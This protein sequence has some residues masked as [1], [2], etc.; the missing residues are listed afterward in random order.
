MCEHIGNSWTTLVKYNFTI[1]RFRIKKTNLVVIKNSIKITSVLM[2]SDR[3]YLARTLSTASQQKGCLLYL[4]IPR[5][6]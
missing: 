1:S 2:M 3:E 6:N 5:T 4:E